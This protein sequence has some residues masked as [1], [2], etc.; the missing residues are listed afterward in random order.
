M[1]KKTIILLFNL[2]AFIV[3]SLFAVKSL[4]KYFKII[5]FASKPKIKV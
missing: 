4:Q 2:L 5:T 1:I 3:L